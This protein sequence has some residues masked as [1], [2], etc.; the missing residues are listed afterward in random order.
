VREAEPFALAVG[1]V[2]V[3]LTSRVAREKARNRS[4]ALKTYCIFFSA[5]LS[6]EG[7]R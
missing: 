2:E 4:I 6:F 1:F 7:Y 5:T 3:G